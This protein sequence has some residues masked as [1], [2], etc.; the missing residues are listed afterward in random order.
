MP[1]KKMIITMDD[2]NAFV[3][4]IVHQVGQALFDRL[5][6]VCINMNIDIKVLLSSCSDYN[7]FWGLVDKYYNDYVDL[8][9]YE[10]A[11]N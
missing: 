1:K 3:H 4:S 10:D 8:E 9:E 6:V 5:K 11:S 7:S 2:W